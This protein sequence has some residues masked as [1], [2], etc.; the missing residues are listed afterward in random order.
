MQYKCTHCKVSPVEIPSQLCDKCKAT[1]LYIRNGAVTSEAIEQM[2]I[3]AEIATAVT[4]R[5]QYF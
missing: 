5:N 1:G 4:I 3:E 2:V